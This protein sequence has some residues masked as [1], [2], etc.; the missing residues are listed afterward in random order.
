MFGSIEDFTGKADFTVFASVYE[1]FGHMI[2]PEEVLM[3]VVEAEVTGGMLKLLVREVVPIRK[4]RSTMVRKV[5]L[6]V[7]A[8]E[9]VQIEKLE[10]V[11]KL[12]T[13][14]KGGIPVDFEVKV[15]SGENIETM[16]LFARS[17]PIDAEES[18][19]EK[20]EEILG[21]DNVRITG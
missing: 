12:C 11:K 1:Q 7:D 20:L 15:Q 9:Q 10:K 8:D 13:E 3:L 16:T 2:K 4:V 17:T 14:K 21:P 18:T 5:I 19:I 6:K